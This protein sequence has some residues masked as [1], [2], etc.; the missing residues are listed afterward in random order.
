MKNIHAADILNDNLTFVEVVF[1]QNSKRDGLD[2]KTYTYKTSLEVAVGDQFIVEVN[3]EGGKILKVVTVFNIL[4]IEDVDFDANY[5]YRHLVQK[6][7]RSF[8]EAELEAE[9][10]LL[11]RIAELRRNSVRNGLTA[12][13][14]LSQRDLMELGLADTSQL[15]SQP[16]AEKTPSDAGETLRDL[17]AKYYPEH[18]ETMKISAGGRE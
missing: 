17:A 18:V 3:N 10:Q 5:A 1:D 13:L 12:S 7:D 9:K 4:D 14:G 15:L 2:P 11:R 8:Y 16:I 6:V